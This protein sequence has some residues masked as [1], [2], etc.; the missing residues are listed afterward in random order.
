MRT[1]SLFKRL[2]GVERAVIEGVDF[3][4]S[5]LVVR[6]RLHKR[7][8]RRCSRCGRRC[9][10]HDSGRGRRRWR[11]MDFGTVR[12]WLEAEAPRV[13]C[14]RHGVVIARVTWARA[15]SG[16]TYDFED[17]VAWLATNTSQ[18]TVGEMM[19]ISWRTVGRVLRRVVE[20]RR[21]GVDL[22]DGLTR[23]GID[24][25][26]YR[27][28]HRYLTVVVCHDTG[29]LVWAHPGNSRAT[30]EMFFAALG[31]ERRGR[32][33]HVT[34]DGA[35]WIHDTVRSHCEEA[36]VCLDAFHIV[37]WVNDAVDTVR[38]E[39]W[40]EQRR[41]GDKQ[42]AGEVKGT[43]WALLKNPENLT[44]HQS[45][46]LARLEAD[47]SALYRAYLLKEQL[48]LLLRQPV[49]Q[50]IPLLD[51]W[52]E[53]ATKSGLASFEKVAR[54]IVR[55]RTAIEAMLRHSLTNGRIES[56]N[57]KIRLIQRR[58]YGF[59]DPFALIALAQLTLSGLC[60]PLPG[61]GRA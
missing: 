38:R 51:G 7:Q 50:A 36:E 40:N 44:G 12:V 37:A 29:R 46:M 23:I 47:N 60:P 56:I 53:G 10:L 57:A 22:L 17:Q 42:L 58:A 1:S 39:L 33:T 5:D 49:E 20:E 32:I 16:F 48:R 35:E 41:S 8:Q 3:E 55:Q 59:H 24:E 13:R 21:A 6:V 2:L 14:L 18:S 27:R 54:T 30:L 28:G 15:G 45:G 31:E 61:R 9:G 34:C 25:T 52:V 26:S 19:R 43:R 11:V 4:G